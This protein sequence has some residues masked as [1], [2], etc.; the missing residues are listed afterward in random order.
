MT[1]RPPTRKLRVDR[2]IIA[3]VV[4][5]GAAFAGYWFGIR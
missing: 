1:A 2:V 4:L 3:L 5:G